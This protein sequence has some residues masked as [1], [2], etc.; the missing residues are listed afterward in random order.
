MKVTGLTVIVRECNVRMFAE[1][2]EQNYNNCKP[3]DFPYDFDKPDFEDCAVNLEYDIFTTKTN[4]T[5]YRSAVA[6]LVKFN[7]ININNINIFYF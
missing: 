1:M 3:D 2:V 5:M 7:F 4:M 6:K